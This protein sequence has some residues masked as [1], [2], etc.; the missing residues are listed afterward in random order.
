M[1]VFPALAAEA[2]SK[3]PGKPSKGSGASRR[4]KWH[5]Y[6]R[7][8][9][10]DGPFPGPGRGGPSQASGEALQ[11][12]RGLPEAKM[13][14]LHKGNYL[15]WPFPG[16]AAEA[17]SK[18]PG[19]SFQRPRG[20]PEAKMASLHKGDCLGWPFSDNGRGGPSQA[21][22]GALQGPG[23]SRRPKWHLYTRRTV[24]DCLF[25]A[26]AVTDLSKPPGEPFHR[27]TAMLLRFFFV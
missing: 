13:A 24:L 6:T 22:G 27:S 3:P 4:P 26:V 10:L 16:P 18:P 1:A 7:G 9:V 11:G 25:P 5:P 17:L 20:L 14:S 2:L 23:A 19:E 15:G 8:T 21:S 12:P